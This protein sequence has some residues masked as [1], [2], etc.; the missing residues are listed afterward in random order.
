MMCVRACVLK[1]LMYNCVYAYLKMCAEKVY[2]YSYYSYI[3]IYL[4]LLLCACMQFIES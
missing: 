4:L 1:Y 3:Y 2:I